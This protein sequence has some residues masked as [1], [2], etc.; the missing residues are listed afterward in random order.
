MIVETT[1]T[2]SRCTPYS[3]Y[4]RMVTHVCAALEALLK[5]NPWIRKAEPRRRR[6]CAASGPTATA[7]RGA[8][9]PLRPGALWISM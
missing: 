5:D 4:F 6:C 2:Y 1:L 9:S 7:G 8:T 3:I